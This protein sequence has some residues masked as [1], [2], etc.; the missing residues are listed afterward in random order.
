MD[1]ANEG[2]LLDQE[3]GDIPALV[4]DREYGLIVLVNQQ[5]VDLVEYP[6]GELNGH[7]L[8]QI[9]PYI[10][11]DTL[12]DHSFVEFDL[13]TNSGK[14][15]LAGTSIDFVT[16]DGGNA[17]LKIR[18]LKLKTAL[19]DPQSG[20][21]RFEHI[22]SLAKLTEEQSFENAQKQAVRILRKVFHANIVNIY[23]IDEKEPVLRIA[24][25]NDPFHMMPSQLPSTDLVMLSKPLIWKNDFQ[26]PAYLS[27][28][29]AALKLKYLISI[30]LGVGDGVTGLVLIGDP[31]HEPIAG[32][33]QVMELVR[34][35]FNSTISHFIL[36]E[37]LFEEIQ[38][39]NE[40]LALRN[41]ELELLK[42]GIIVVSKD[43]KIIE[44]N[45][46]IETLLGYREEEIVGMQVEDILIGPPILFSAFQ[47][48][49]QGIAA[50]NM[51][52]LQIHHRV[53]YPIS[54]HMQIIPLSIEKDFEKII[55]MI[56]D[57][58]KFEEITLR[59]QQLEHRAILGEF[60]SAFAHDVRN[61]I[62]NMTSSL[63]LLNHRLPEDLPEQAIIARLNEDCDR[64]T[65]LMESFLS[66]SRLVDIRNFQELDVGVLLKKICSKWRPSLDNYGIQLFTNIPADLPKIK[67]DRR[68]LERVFVNLFSNAVDATE[69]NQE[70]PILGVQ[71]SV[72][73]K[74]ATEKKFI[75]VSISDNGKG[76]PE[77]LKDHIFEPFFSTKTE[78]T[79]LGLAISKQIVTAH[80]GSIIVDTFPG[81]TV[82][83]VKL[84][85]MEV[86]DESD[87]PG[88]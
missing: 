41:R 8:S 76:I 40:T 33:N 18:R 15:Y 69:D 14:L 53:G 52:T 85:V 56:T 24:A 74:S 60:I 6:E 16:K 49:L 19:I 46:A 31:D 5:M 13:A 37:N 3:L 7:H 75:Q 45:Q 17:L 35:N 64:L 61:P 62:N 73:D 28:S 26:L 86:L 83:N 71:I 4:F 9:F 68:S 23:W 12:E 65:Q 78:G 72:L 55:V 81:G 54:V 50:H 39:L 63:Q 47:N 38:Q 10:D 27:T 57:V 70:R 67:A 59:T 51:G 29:N 20:R 25:S 11:L 88:D 22:L 32:I 84:P 2:N 42:D 80:Q 82:F 36:T 79:G 30:P 1:N 58:S 44:I 87:N 66:F 34:A 77:D 21:N 43:L 48:A